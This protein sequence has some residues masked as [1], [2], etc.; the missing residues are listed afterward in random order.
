MVKG[1]SYYS[2]TKRVHLWER[3]QNARIPD[4]MRALCGS[5]YDREGDIYPPKTPTPECK[6]CAKTGNDRGT[7]ND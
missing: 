3:A 7:S 1:A 4:L 6:R 5:I 2:K